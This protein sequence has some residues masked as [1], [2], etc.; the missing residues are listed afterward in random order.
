MKK[1]CVRPLA[2][3]KMPS[4]RLSGGSEDTHKNSR[5]FKDSYRITTYC[6]DRMQAREF[7]FLDLFAHVSQEL[8]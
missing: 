8:E 3:L 4:K 6:T 5:P 1:K 2:F 7:F